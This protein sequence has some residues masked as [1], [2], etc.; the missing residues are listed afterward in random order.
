MRAEQYARAKALFAEVCDLPEPERSERLRAATEDAEI[1]R[2][3]IA[4]ADQSETRGARLAQPVRDAIQLIS[5]EALKP[6]DILDA[7]KLIAPIGQGG[8]GSLFLVE[9]NDG[10]FRQRAAL[11]VLKGLPH[12]QAMELLARERQLLASLTH[13]NI[14]RLLDGGATAG[15]QPYLVMEYIDGQPIDQYCRTHRLSR[16][17]ILR[18]FLRA[19]P[20]VAFAHRQLV[21]HCDIKPANLLVNTEGRP[22][23]LDFGIAQL[24]R[25]SSAP[26]EGAGLLSPG[27]TPG[28]ASPEQ[29]RHET[30]TILSDIYSLGVLLGDILGL[31]ERLA[32][33]LRGR[34]LAAI[35]ARC[36][37]HDPAQRYGSVDALADD[38][39]RW[40]AHKP[41]RAMVAGPLYVARRALRRHW[42]LFLVGA[43]FVATVLLFS[44]WL[45]LESER[46]RAAEL[47][48]VVQRDRAQSAERSAVAERD[49]ALAAEAS[50]R[51]ISDFLVSVFEYTGPDA[52]SGNVPT[53]VLIDAALKR[54]EVELKEQPGSQAE[55]Y[56]ALGRAQRVMGN[57]DGANAN[58][59][60]AVALERTLERPLVLARLLM[61]RAEGLVASIAAE[62]ALPFAEEALRL[63][64]AHAPAGSELVAGAYATL[65][66][67][68]LATGQREAS[69][70]ALKQAL[71]LREMLD[72]DSV[73]TAESLFDLGRHHREFD[74]SEQA[75]A[76]LK[77]ASERFRALR[78][79][80]DHDYLSSLQ[81]LGGSLLRLRRFNEAEAVQRE[82]L[83]I[84]R[85]V[86]QH[87][88]HTFWA[89][90]ELGRVLDRAGRSREALPLFAEAEAIG[91]QKIG[92]L[93]V[94]L[95]VLHT[96]YAVACM[97]A[98]EE[99]CAGDHFQR[100][101]AISRQ[102]WGED[103][104][105]LPRLHIDRAIWLMRSGRRAEAR[106]LLERAW[107]IQLAAG[108]EQSVLLAELKLLR[109]EWAIRAD[110]PAQARE[111]L[112][113]LEHERA[114]LDADQ[115]AALTLV[116]ALVAAAGTDQAAAETAFK[117]SV[118]IHK[119]T[120]GRND[121][122][123]WQA[124][125]EQALWLSRQTDSQMRGRGLRLAALCQRKLK[126]L[127]A[128]Q[129]PAFVTLKRILARG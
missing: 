73:Q 61:A 37:A 120:Y 46:A 75:V 95:L 3:V 92:E 36:T 71:M 43:A 17:A 116:E 24:V 124:Q 57:A 121:A 110:A 40:L 33:S 104:S 122:R 85:A 22:M 9:R 105:K 41:V 88:Q 93:T 91:R 65:G 106:P 34:E 55:L 103:Q 74:R 44:G 90:S 13:P 68:Q 113:R 6:G 58:L 111:W 5:E 66:N 107:E 100:A 25:T 12:T 56:A 117:R 1:I 20:A 7:W 97:R 59:A 123:Y 51:Q 11:K 96:H 49:R 118:Q 114:L 127:L 129:A 77:R 101:L 52:G 10:H 83:R 2:F 78:G 45:L 48:A 69:E 125:V 128:A 47:Q 86:H 80:Q 38:L 39:D 102:L 108:S 54:V 8:M 76:Y 79:E 87:S 32:R 23:L 63:M 119:Q 14:A 27:Y 72:P 62:E 82:S 50:S 15:G 4:L 42:P 112:A 60:R 67:V 35:V 98:G 53:A 29:R 64:L 109:A 30:V 21:V 18:M 115:Q 81:A 28:Y 70:Q 99:S 16:P 84:H 26:E 89:L 31:K 19:L 126:T 94:P